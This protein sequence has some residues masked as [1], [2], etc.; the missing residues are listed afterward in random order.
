MKEKED[1]P[2]IIPQNEYKPDLEREVAYYL[3]ISEK[4]TFISTKRYTPNKPPTKFSSPQEEAEFQVE[5]IRRIING[6]DGL[7]GKGYGWLNYAKIRVMKKGNIRGGKISPEFR[8]AQEGWFRKVESL[9]GTGRGLIGYKRRRFGFSWM[10]A[11]DVYHDCLTNPYFQVGMNSKGEVDSRR[12][13]GFV[14]FLHAESPDWLRPRAGVTDR[15]DYMEFAYWFDKVKKK[16]V[17]SKGLNTEKRGIQSWINS[18]PPT[19]NGHEGQL[20]H[21]L[22]IDEAGKIDNLMTIWSFA[23]DCLLDNTERV[24]IP[25]IMGTVGDIDKDG[26]GLMEMYRNNESYDL[27]RFAIHGYNGLLVDE[28][29][30]D[31]IE[32]AIRWVVYERD[33]RKA[34]RRS[35]RETFI[36]K[37]P[38]CEKDAFNQVTDGG[39]GNIMTINDQITKLSYNPAEKRV[40]WMRPKQDGTVD[41]VPNPAGKIIVYEVPDPVRI[42]G[43]V[44]GA[45]PADHDDV[46]KSRDS[47]NLALAIVAKPFGIAPPKLVLEYV[48]RPD[49]LDSFFEQSAMALKW[50][51][52]TKVLAEDNRARMV[53]YFKEHYMDL[54]PLVPKSIATARG[55]FDMKHSVKMTEE[56]KQQMMGLIEDNIDNYSEYIPSI[57]LLEEFKV[58]GDP[59]GED[60]LAIAYGWALVMLQADKKPA[61]TST[62]AKPPQVQLQRIGGR[63]I[64]VN[65][66]EPMK[67]SRRVHPLYGR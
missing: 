56:R 13:F 58:F 17:S 62:A 27:D 19:D 3:S 28:F 37:Y 59:H 41:F 30:N 45:D 10:G 9:E 63:L 48:D 21:K 16:I 64:M 7:S 33:K 5:E 65:H 15:R 25:I 67:G 2:G 40:G 34:S 57:R 43:Y 44:A 12:L 35:I 42:N 36:Q 31:M 61:S 47:S 20:Y 54:L 18:T 11:W 29:G 51:N 6:Y 39:V 24:G 66:N 1:R 60:D 8:S 49:K 38:L 4:P 53:N 32:D 23:E 55:G 26:K 22:L 14:K 46:K 52:H 50:Y